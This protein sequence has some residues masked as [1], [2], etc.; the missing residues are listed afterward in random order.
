MNIIHYNPHD[1]KVIA[2]YIDTLNMAMTDDVVSRNASTVK[3][4][5]KE[6]TSQ[7]ADIINIHG[8]WH[9]SLPIVMSMAKKH[10]ARIV[11]TPHGQLE[12]WIMSRQ[13]TAL[14]LFRQTTYQRRLIRQAYSVI[15]MGEMEYMNTKRLGWSDRIETVSNSLFTSKTTDSQMAKDTIG[16]FQKVM[17]SNVFQAMDEITRKAL[18][19][20]FKAAVTNNRQWI[21]NEEAN[22]I[23]ALDYHQWR[24]I[25]I[26]GYSTS[27]LE[28][29]LHGAEVFSITPPDCHPENIKHYPAAR[30]RHIAE[31][32]SLPILKIGDNGS[33]SQDDMVEMIR[34][35]KEKAD[36]KT[37]GI[38]DILQLA[39]ALFN[40]RI[41]EDELRYKL[42][43]S[44]LS[45]F[46]ARAMALCTYF[47][48]IPE[49]FLVTHSKN[50]RKTK[51]IINS[52]LT[53]LKL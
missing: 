39:V 15:V 53:Q 26:Y 51:A 20:L 29:I 40:L 12:P 37:I 52:I 16:V 42:D 7:H 19:M 50:D 45:S 6:L 25:M 48:C 5:K 47:T 18:F 14:R 11:V 24:Q 1:D 49:G 13:N 27:S 36:Q 28:Y 32:K 43:E 2:E 31:A 33:H 23:G 21:D 46:A 8:C 34:A 38:A 44:Q 41:N 22:L 4:I 30:A 3:E 35:I 17:D 10:N 9:H